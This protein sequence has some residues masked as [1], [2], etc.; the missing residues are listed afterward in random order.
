MAT[1]VGSVEGLGVKTKYHIEVLRKAIEVAPADISV[2][3]GHT[4]VETRIPKAS[5]IV[6]KE[7]PQENK[8]LEVQSDVHHMSAVNA[9][10]YLSL[11]KEL[12]KEEVWVSEEMRSSIGGLEKLPDSQSEVVHMATA[13]GSGAGVLVETNHVEMLHKA[14]EVVPKEAM[15][16]GERDV[17]G[18]NRQERFEVVFE[19]EELF[20]DL[21]IAKNQIELQQMAPLGTEKV[22]SREKNEV[23][24]KKGMAIGS[25]VL[26]EQGG[27]EELLVWPPTVIV[28]NTRV[29]KSN[30][31][32]WTGIGN[33]E[34]T[35]FLRG[36]HYY[37]FKC[38]I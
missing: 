37:I 13:V 22:F 32:R 11:D 4:V 7:E 6:E 36:I 5:S 27:P 34:M 18:Q 17:D 9:T 21:N 19:K 8:M 30:D 28:E 23:P 29:G 16:V 12:M 35:C 1:N 38:N 14:I 25:E 20:K 24:E 33:I 2:K 15:L 26:V 3:E 10:E 31:G